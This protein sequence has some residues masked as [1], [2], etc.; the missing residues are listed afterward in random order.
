M[1][2]EPSATSED[3]HLRH[4]NLRV[5]HR[6]QHHPRPAPDLLRPTRPRHGHKAHTFLRHPASFPPSHSLRH[7]HR[8][9]PSLRRRIRPHGQKA[10]RPRVGHHPVAKNR[11]GPLPRHVLHG[12]GRRHGEQEEGSSG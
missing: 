5:H 12:G 8:P 9:R 1:H 11:V 4:P 2:H 7:P 6:L 3:P 10:H